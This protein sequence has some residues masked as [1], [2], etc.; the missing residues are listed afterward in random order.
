M[1][2]FTLLGEQVIRLPFILHSS[3]PHEL[4][5]NWW[6]NGVY[7]DF[8]GGNWCEG[9]TAYLA[10]HL[11]AEQRGQGAEHRRAILQRITDYV[12]PEND[13]PL[14]RF[15]GRYD[16]ATEAIGYG[17][18]AMI[19]NMLREQVGDEIFV[20]ALR[21]FYREQRF[22]AAG[23]SDIR[24]SFEAASGRD[25]K[26][27]FAQWVDHAGTPELVLEGVQASGKQL[28]I[29]LAQVQRGR[30]FDLE[31]PLAIQT[32]TGV[33][34][35]KITLSADSTRVQQRFAL[36]A[37]PLR[38]EVDPQFQV[39][40]RLSPLETPPALSN[41]LGASRVLIV[42][43]AGGE[44]LYAGLVQAWRADGV[45]VAADN[46]LEQLP[47]DKAIW[48]LGAGNKFAPL[49]LAALKPWGA[50]FD[51]RGL[52]TVDETFAPE[53]RSFVVGVRHPGNPA[54]VVILVSAPSAAASAALARKLPHYG[55][56]SWLVFAGDDATN[57][58]KGEWPTGDTPLSRNLGA[59][60]TAI[61]L[62]LRKA[63]AEL[64]PPSDA[65]PSKTA[66]D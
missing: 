22:R 30:R 57:E 61:K 12:T 11:V 66:T 23:F 53:N 38:V 52:H 55:K 44:A 18:T 59:A 4:L 20:A 26:P 49:V 51:A 3:Y 56:Y 48:L 37:P 29:T 5:H 41:A 39:Y 40:R 32:S 21:A 7:V 33:L 2:S 42:T 34:L 64:G 17:K 1:P 36:D 19:W 15:V 8:A 28:D 50:T 62:P 35:R 60:G 14:T 25:L 45:E 63:L 58:G 65:A 46:Q 9:L 24:S 47:A 13:F 10:D 43:P 27:F 31:V 16:P 6:G 54:S